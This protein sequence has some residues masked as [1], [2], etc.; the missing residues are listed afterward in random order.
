LLDSGD[1]DARTLTRR[2]LER[3]SGSGR[4]LNCFVTLCADTALAEARA[5]AERA[6]AGRRIGPLDGV[7]V[8]LK[9]NIDVAGVPTSNGF[10][11]VPWRI[12]TED[13][14]VVRLLRA[15]GA[16]VLGK[17]NMHEG[18]LGAMTD[19]PHHGRTGNPHRAGHSP[20]GSSGGSGAAVA[21]GLCCAAL[22]TDTGGS[23]RIPASYCGVV[24]LKPST[25]LLSTRGVV[26][27]SRRLDHVGPLTRT[28]AD[29]AIILEALG[30]PAC[31]PVPKR[32]DGVRLGVI[33]NF[34]TETIAP[35]VIAAFDTAL[36][37]LSGLGAVVRVFDLHGFDPVKARRAGF[38]R[39]EA[40]AAF[41]HAALYA[42]EPERFSAEMRYY[43]DYGAKMSATRLIAVDEV[44]D[45][46]ASAFVRCFADFDAIVSP[47]TPQTAPAFD[48]PA[49]DN[50]GTFCVLANFAGTPAISVPMGRDDLGLPLGLQIC[51]PAGV[52]AVVLDIAEAY[53]AAA[54]P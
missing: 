30:G 13:A 47:A 39:V 8:A 45:A 19:N 11:G 44:I 52:E 9:D 37:V 32:L 1:L 50:A 34:T 29:S 23:V 26:P 10:G 41:H 7:P 14:D 5:A 38:L 46:A 43:L 54:N 33:A 48:L 53:E 15:A 3:E 31:H 24:G 17:L 28:V 40:E 12:P 42:R 25:G 18:A 2:F 16:V 49:P 35:S 51:G 27:L 22:G 36:G 20:G 6:A 4:A 21:A